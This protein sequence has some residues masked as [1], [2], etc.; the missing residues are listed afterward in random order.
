[1][2]RGKIW[3]V[4]GGGNYVGK[5]RPAVIV[6]NDDFDDT[7]SITFC[8]FTT[9]TAEAPLMWPWTANTG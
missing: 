9:D 2:K 7:D 5:P 8:P 1:M 4:A 3:T 6:Q